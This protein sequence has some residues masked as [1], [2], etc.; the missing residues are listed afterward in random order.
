MSRAVFKLKE[1][2]LMCDMAVDLSNS[3]YDF[4]IKEERTCEK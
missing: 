3:I 2:F 4:K 1:S